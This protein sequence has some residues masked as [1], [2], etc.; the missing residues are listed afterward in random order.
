[1]TII[2]L[3]KT[4]KHVILAHL[5]V[6]NARAPLIVPSALSN[7]ICLK[8][9]AIKHNLLIVIVINKVIFVDC[10][11]IQQVVKLVIQMIIA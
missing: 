7:F 3:T 1:M 5:I 4:I 10:V 9:A 2:I 8:E 6:S 11:Q